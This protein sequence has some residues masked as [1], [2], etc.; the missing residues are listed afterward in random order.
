MAKTKT[1][2]KIVVATLTT[3]F[4]LFS[5]FSAT[6]AWFAANSTAEATGMQ[7]AVTSGGSCDLDDIK[8]IKFDYGMSTIG[9]V[10]SIDYLNPE[11][12]E[13]SLY[14]YNYDYHSFGEFSSG[15]KYYQWNGESWDITDTVPLSGASKGTVDYPSELEELSPDIND[16]YLVSNGN[17][18]NVDAMNVYDPVDMVV[19]RSSLKD[20]NCNAVYEMS[21]VSQESSTL[22]LN[23]TSSLFTINNLGDDILLSDCVDFDVYYESDLLDSNELFVIED[24]NATTMV[25]EYDDKPYYP[26]Y[27]LETN[28]NYYQ[29][30][31]S[32]WDQTSSEPVS[33]TDKGTVKYE[34]CLPESPSTNDYYLVLKT[35]DTM[36]SDEEEIYYK[37]SYLSSLKAANEHSHFYGSP[38]QRNITI[39]SNKELT[40][41]SGVPVKIY[42]N[43]NYAPSKADKYLDRIS[44]SDVRA[45]YDYYFDFA[46]NL[47]GAS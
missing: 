46:F 15:V 28:N 30:N 26:S 11:T 27:K 16:Y 7:I 18:N 40:F 29:W 36:S 21:F 33:G 31:G 37:I 17:W 3:V 12:G 38:K 1:R 45:R 20:M 39:A 42:I 2:L 25:N 35:P 34:S 13:V 14:D 24:D 9:E 8:L 22:L 5:A 43:V 47:G 41:T 4:S 6:I 19:R 32:S 10:T 44:L 23:L